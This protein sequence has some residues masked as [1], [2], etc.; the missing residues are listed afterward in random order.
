MPIS[1]ARKIAYDV[2]LRVETG[3]AY[4]SDL[5]HA[6]MNESVSS[7]DAALATELVMGTLRWQRLLDFFIERYTGKKTSALDGEV[8]VA[9][10]LGIYQLRHLARIPARAA[11]SESV[12]LVKQARKKSAASLTNAVLRRAASEKDQPA[13]TFLPPGATAADNLGIAHSHPSWMVERWL[14]QFGRSRT[15]ALLDGNNQA[16]NRACALREIGDRDAVIQS[17]AEEGVDCEPVRLLRDA[18]ILRSGDIAKTKAFQQGRIV[19]QDEASQMIPLLL[20]VKRGE[21]VLDVC[22]APGGK[23]LALASAAGPEALVVAGDLHEHRLRTMRER[24]KNSHVSHVQMV[25]L[26]GTSPLPFRSRFDRILVDA[27]CSGVGTL[28]RNPE[29]RWRLK[30]EDLAD[31][32]DRQVRLLSFALECLTANGQLLYSTCSLE[33]EEN[34]QVIHGALA[35]HSEFQMI[36]AEIPDGALAN[37]VRAETLTAADGTFRTFPPVHGTDGFFAAVLRRS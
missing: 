23:T 24:L 6:R 20:D 32:H 2:L 12:E 26:D 28:A 31:L 16:P 25:V 14:K 27:P 17:L 22:A 10:R 9:L 30:P 8:Q 33:P 29:I 37:G 7:R 3:Q 1:R 36:P 11:V 35:A 19:I 21:S 5:L 34:E 13:E 15:V 4:A 18:I